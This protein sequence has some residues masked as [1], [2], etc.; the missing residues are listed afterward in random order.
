MNRI[1]RTVMALFAAI[2]LLVGASGCGSVVKTG[3]DYQAVWY[4]DGEL[5]AQKFKDC[6]D[7]AVRDRKGLGDKFYFYPVGDRTFSFTGRPGS[8]SGPVTIKTKD[9]QEMSVLG[10]IQFELTTDCEVLR[11]FHEQIGLKY[12]AYFDDNGKSAGWGE[13]LN[14][15]FAVPLNSIMD[16]AGLQQNWNDLYS[17]SAS[18]TTFEKYVVD[19]LGAEIESN[20]PAGFINVKAVSIETPNPS[21]GLRKNLEARENAKA[22]KQVQDEKNKVRE[23]KYAGAAECMKVFTKEQCLVLELAE[24]GDIPFYPVPQGGSINVTPKQ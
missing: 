3:Q 10:F 1:V 9:S 5:S 15:Y 24:K 22:E 20:L 11:K 18:V 6:V 4:E 16:K 14:D 19:N 7:P 21:E 12:G 13:F 2:A 23:S 17:N 8:E